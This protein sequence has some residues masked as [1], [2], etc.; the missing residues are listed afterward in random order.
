M[1]NK[2][3]E[4]LLRKIL[5]LLLIILVF[6][7]IIKECKLIGFCFTIIS[8]ISPLFFGFVIA[9]L[10]KPIML[11]INKKFNTTICTI[12]TYVIIAIIIFILGFITIP[13]IIKEIKNIIPLIID[14]YQ[15]IPYKINIDKM[16]TIINNKTLKLKTII[17]NIFYSTF[18]SFFYLLSHKEVSKSIKKYTPS[19]LISKIS[20][21]LRLFV[22][23]TIIDTLI[24]FITTF[25]SL[26]IIRVPYSLLLALIISLTNIIPYIGPY[27]GAIPTILVGFSVNTKVGIISIIIIILLQF[28]ESTFIHPIIMSKSLKISP[29]YIII[30]LI[31]CG[32]FFGIIGMIISTP[33]VSIIKTT[34]DYYKKK[35]LN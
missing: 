32:Y 4:P 11:K 24:L 25:I 35:K 34:Y 28:I 12:L 23:G 29:I 9:W 22:K 14:I 2:L 8:L 10:L 18:I 20:K 31:I 21:N 5:Y 27:I 7:F 26:L 6:L 30:S 17:L 19:K 3:K 13:I 16:L 1:I 15:K 33:V